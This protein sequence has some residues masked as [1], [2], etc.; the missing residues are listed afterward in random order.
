[1]VKVFL[2]GYFDLNY[3]TNG[4]IIPAITISK[5]ITY[6]TIQTIGFD[7]TYLH[8]R[9]ATIQIITAVA[10]PWSADTTFAFTPQADKTSDTAYKNVTATI[11]QK[12]TLFSPQLDLDDLLD[13][14]LEDLELLELF[15]V[16]A[17]LRPLFN[18]H[19]HFNFLLDK[20]QIF[21]IILRKKS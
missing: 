15:L 17:I 5:Q 10:S 21:I 3:I 16:F 4:T 20:S 1:M 14:E 7:F 6:K 9:I 8:A 19:L 11:V 2:I 12:E 18:N 13:E